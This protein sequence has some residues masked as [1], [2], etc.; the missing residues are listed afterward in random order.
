MRRTIRGF[1]LVE[2]LVVIGII[3]I[4]IGVLLPALNRARQAAYATK[5]ASNLRAIGQGLLMYVSEQKGTFPAAYIYEGMKISGGVE[6]PDAAVNGYVHWSSFIFRKSRGSSLDMFKNPTGWEIFQCPVI[7][8]GGLPPTNTYPQN[9]DAGQI[10]DNGP[11]VIDQQA[12][13]CAYTVNEAIMPRNKFVIGFQGAKRVYQFVRASQIKKSAQTVLATEWNPD[14]HIVAEAGRSDPST[15]VCKSHR[16]VH[17][18][19]GIGGELNMETIAPDPFAGRPTYRRVTVAELSPDP[20]AGGTFATRLDWV[21]RNHGVKK[22]EHGFDVRKSE[23]LYV[24][25]HVEY[26]GIKETLEPVFEWGDRMYSL[27][28]NGDIAP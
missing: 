13:R 21:G 2:L 4:L 1:T 5:C 7:E 18:F 9:L 11:T 20:R 24:D 28:P 22:L 25:G 16:P 27:S 8:N 6:T 26:K 15:T 12:P 19:V 10:N 3:A 23:F 17:A 14:W